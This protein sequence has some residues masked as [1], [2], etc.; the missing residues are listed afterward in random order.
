MIL[1]PISK[2]KHELNAMHLCEMYQFE[3]QAVDNWEELKVKLNSFYDQSKQ[4]RLLEIFTPRTI[5]D[6]ILIDYFK[7]FN[8]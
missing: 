5:N 2:P 1:I 4:P 7:S 6:K 3:Y 8:D